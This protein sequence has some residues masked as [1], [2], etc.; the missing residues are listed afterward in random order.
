MLSPIF[1]AEFFESSYGFRPGKS[2]HQA[3]KPTK[4]YIVRG[5]RV[6]VDLDLETF[7]DRVKHDILMAK[8]AKRIEDELVLMLI[9]RYLEAGMMAE[10][11]SQ[12]KQAGHT[13]R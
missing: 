12:P 10:V 4:Q 8:L 2:A 1:D 9:R 7:F 11:V 13:A 5:R 3:V 6:V